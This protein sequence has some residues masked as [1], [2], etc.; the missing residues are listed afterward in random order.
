MPVVDCCFVVI[1]LFSNVCAL[2]TLHFSFF[3]AVLSISRTFYPFSR[4]HRMN[5]I[6]FFKSM[7]NIYKYWFSLHFLGTISNEKNK[8]YDEGKKKKCQLNVFWLSQFGVIMLSSDNDSKKKKRKKIHMTK[9]PRRKCTQKQYERCFCR[10]NRLDN[11]ID[12]NKVSLFRSFFFE[13]LRQETEK[14]HSWNL[15]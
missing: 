15:S 7:A 2:C 4:N 1:S 6:F 11:A 5:N 13:A 12:N 8:K 3:L 9:Y 14:K 10:L